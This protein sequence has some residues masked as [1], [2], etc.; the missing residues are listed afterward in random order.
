MGR[1]FPRTLIVMVSRLIGLLL[2]EKTRI[3]ALVAVSFACAGV[4][5]MRLSRNE[6]T[7]DLVEF[8]ISPLEASHIPAERRLIVDVSP[9]GPSGGAHA[10][11]RLSEDDWDGQVRGLLE[12]WSPA[13]SMILISSA[14]APDAGIRMRERLIRDLQIPNVYVLDGGWEAWNENLSRR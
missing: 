11:S 3:L 2:K 14:S 13:S 5:G 1:L 4:Q 8:R 9:T 12:Q 10:A 7:W 6:K